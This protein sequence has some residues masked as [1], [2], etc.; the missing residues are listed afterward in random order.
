MADKTFGKY[1]VLEHL[2]TGAYA[3]VYKALDQSLRRTMDPVQF[4]SGSNQPI[5]ATW[6]ASAAR[7]RIQ[8]KII[9]IARDINLF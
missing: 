9:W 7:F 2:G 6:P 5:Q 4:A 1:Q 8:P 3:D